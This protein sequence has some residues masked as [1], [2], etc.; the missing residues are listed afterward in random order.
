M[1]KQTF[2]FTLCATG[3]A[4]CD[5]IAASQA[6]EAQQQKPPELLDTSQKTTSTDVLPSPQEVA[7][8]QRAVYRY[9]TCGSSCFT[10]DISDTNRATCT[11]NCR[12]TLAA[13]LA[14]S[15]LQTAAMAEVSDITHRLQ[16]CDDNCADV[17]SPDNRATCVLTC[18]SLVSEE[19]RQPEFDLNAEPDPV[20]TCD[21]ACDARLSAC[22]SECD[23]KEYL[24]LD[25]LA[26]CKLV[27]EN[28]ESACIRECHNEQVGL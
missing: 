28:T 17:D 2:L 4:G 3:L 16:T 18:T 24:S 26:T 5:I 23:A 6:A 8:A 20:Y 14:R 1:L 25:N 19:Y 15:E 13:R 11:L 12:Q 10:S 21:S 22:Q 9:A 27:C 7:R